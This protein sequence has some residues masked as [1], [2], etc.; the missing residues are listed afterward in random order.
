MI[1][2]TREYFRTIIAEI[3]ADLNEYNQPISDD[4][5]DTILEDTYKIIIG[6]MSSERVDTTIDST[7]DVTI[8][9]YKNGYNKPIQNYDLG[10][11]KAI[12]IQAYAMK[13]NNISQLTHIKAITSNGIN[14][15]TINSN[16]NL[17]KYSIQFTVT[18]SYFYE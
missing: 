7:I 8:H 17:Y 10:Y 1:V 18:V 6:N 13:Q 12:D 15:E 3:D 11:C 9:L 2:E 4:V 16:D 5:A 14:V